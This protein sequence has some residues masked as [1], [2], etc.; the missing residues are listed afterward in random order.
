MDVKLIIFRVRVQPIV[1][2]DRRN[3]AVRHYPASPQAEAT[4]RL[5]RGQLDERAGAELK[6]QEYACEGSDDGHTAEQGD[7]DGKL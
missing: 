6:Q 7:G 4:A 2:P 3:A 5:Q 1:P